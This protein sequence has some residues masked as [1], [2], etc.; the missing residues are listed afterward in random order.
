MAAQSL[1]GRLLRDRGRY[2]EAAETIG[3]AIVSVT[4]GEPGSA[5]DALQDALAQVHERAGDR[6]QAVQLLEQA[7]ARRPQSQELAFALGAAYQRNGQWERA[8]ETVRGSI[9]KRD[10]DNVQAL[11]FIGYAL[12]SKRAAARRGAPPARARAA[13]QAD[14]RRGRRQPRLALR[15]D[16]IGSTTP[17]A[18]WCRPIG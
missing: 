9:L 12:A 8:V 5:T 3:R 17:S 4:G 2:R 14:E 15:E 6:A 16:R 18:C 1:I 10:A 11:N 7:F 13:A